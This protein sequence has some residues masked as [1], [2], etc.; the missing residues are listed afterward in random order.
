[1]S[2]VT[3]RAA[4]VVSRP[5]VDRLLA[6]VPLLSIY[7]WLCVLYGWE[8]FGHVTPWLNSDELET[9]QLSRAVAET[10]ETARRGV[11]Y[12]V[13]ALY[14]YVLAPVWWIQDVG[15]AYATAKFLNVLLMTAVL[16][17]TYG[18]ARM[19]VSRPWALFAATGAATIPAL[20][21]SA[22]LI[23]EPL[24][25]PWAALS[26]F[27][28]AKALAHRTGWWIGGAALA[29]I[30][31]PLVREQ[32]AVV[33]AA[34]VVAAIALAATSARAKREYARWSRW[35]WIG[36]ATLAVGVVIV[37][38]AAISH[39]SYSWLISTIFY[40]DRMLEN[41]LWA[42]GALAIGMG[43]LPMV[44]GLAALVR[45]R[46]ETWSPELRAV[47]ATMGALIVGFGWYT[48]VKAAYIST[49]FSTLVVE[50]NLI[51][52]APLLFVGT[53]MFLERPVVRWWAVAAGAGVT[54]AAI[55]LVYPYQMQFRV[56]SDA[57]GFSL[58]QAAN[59][60]YQWT[61]SHAR[62]VL[63]GMLVVSLVVIVLPRVLPEGQGP[64][65]ALA[66]LLVLTWSLAGQ[67]SAA[68]A[69]N[70]FSETLADDIATPYD[71]ID[72]ETGGA[73]ALYLGQRLTDFNGL[74]QMEFWNRSLKHVWSTDGSAPG[75]GPTLTPDLV[76]A[77]TGAITHAAVEYVVVDPGIDVVGT[78]VGEHT[79]YAGGTPTKWRLFE[80]TPPLRL[81]N[82]ARGVSQDG[83]AE[84]QT[85]YSQF[86][87]PGGQAGFAVVRV[88]RKAWGG[89]DKP[90]RVWIRVGELRRGKDKQPALGAVTASCTFTINRLEDRTFLLRTSRSPFHVDIRIS[91]TF[92]PHE[93]D[94][95]QSDTR[96]LGAQVEY[97]FSP[98]A[99]VP[100]AR[101]GCAA[102][103][104]RSGR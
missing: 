89:I 25:Y 20:Y 39:L 43:I 62:N 1:M 83:W 65:L 80:I 59:R 32:L 100:R 13:H 24:A 47:V 41:G 19:V 15:Q 52:I 9:A 17:P 76:N 45:P 34:F 95:S 6:A 42:V 48:A 4:A 14:P 50:R 103:L 68:S 7:L 85:D 64:V 27:L 88:H 21:Y 40:K 69:S 63:V 71:W 60:A 94:P 44:A 30:A 11:P 51:Y 91:R 16:F 58:L 73:P 55:L 97:S 23:E 46:G 66:A 96:R 56:Y 75:P 74:W 86:T 99:T 61:P 3:A 26:A 38:N 28:I 8:A 10:G 72:R 104:R 102:A 5:R 67:M 87:T 70:T 77:R 22:M 31:A 98:A 57:P 78:K 35:D 82:A 93:L 92:V 2:V 81:Q 37:V 90:A 29:S 79:H 12:P 101:R 49:T 18:L 54:L 53:A 36:G 33:P 84:K